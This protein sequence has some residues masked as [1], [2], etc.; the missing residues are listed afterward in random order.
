MAGHGKPRPKPRKAAAKA[1][2][3]KKTAASGSN[4]TKEAKEL[5][6]LK[7]E[8]DAAN[9]QLLV[10]R[11][12]EQLDEEEA[13]AG[14]PRA[15]KKAKA[16]PA[17][18]EEDKPAFGAD[19]A[20]DLNASLGPW[21]APGS[22]EDE[23]VN[24]GAQSGEE[25]P[26][27]DDDGSAHEGP[28][29]LDDGDEMVVDNVPTG[30]ARRRRRRNGTN[31]DKPAA[32]SSRVTQDS[33]SPLSLRLA[34]AGRSAMRV[35]IATEK[36]FPP[37]HEKWTLATLEKAG[38]QDDSLTQRLALT[39]GND[40][41]RSK[42]INYT[43]GGA[44]QVRGEVK[45]LCV[46]AVSLYGLPGNHSP[47]NIKGIVEWLTS[48]KGIF[49]HG[50]VDVALRAP[51]KRTYNRQEP[52]GHP[53]YQDVISKQWFSSLTSEGV[54][55]ATMAEFVDLNIPIMTLVTD[56]ME[57]ALKQYSTGVRVPVKFT[58]E[59]FGPRYDHHKAT[60]LNL[61]TKSPTWFNAHLH[62]LYSRI[63]NS[64]SFSHLKAVPASQEG[65]ELDDVDFAALE[66]SVA[67]PST[68]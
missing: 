14:V 40:E 66:A 60:L 22:D 54:R 11:N 18:S 36:G 48:T 68:T 67:G 59:E 35:R 49:K 56:A 27:D 43:W 9:A 63:V 55:V 62:N 10:K 44:A 8:L 16:L 23:D 47:D 37:D 13:A 61:Q 24:G 52:F 12:A 38:S 4:K 26:Q 58:E 28:G 53:F 33:F 42:M 41:R 2:T 50:G 65:D 32:S 64:T 15:K 3:V 51:S 5:A 6:R 29:T 45:R 7:K 21:R 34:N 39:K 20:A 57:N 30:K 46:N 19:D 17:S 31:S 25:P 1:A